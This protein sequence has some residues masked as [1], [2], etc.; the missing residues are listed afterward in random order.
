MF[1]TATIAVVATCMECA[2]AVTDFSGARKDL[3]SDAASLG[4]GRV[5]AESY[6]DRWATSCHLFPTL[7][8]AQTSK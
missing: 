3:L 6:L 2:R 5:A 7:Q 1:C 4:L 8:A